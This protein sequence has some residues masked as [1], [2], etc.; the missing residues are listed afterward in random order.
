MG[1]AVSAR[2]YKEG[3]IVCEESAPCAQPQDFLLKLVLVIRAHTVINLENI[4]TNETSQIAKKWCRGTIVI[5]TRYKFNV[6][7]GT[8]IRAS[9]SG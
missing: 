7:L 3:Q 2:T 9:F 4:F 8:M 1:W 5:L 6:I